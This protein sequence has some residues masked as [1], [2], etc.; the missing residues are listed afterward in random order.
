[1]EINIILWLFLM[2]ISLTL[3]IAGILK[4]YLMAFVGS[5]VAFTIVAVFDTIT[6][7]DGSVLALDW[8]TRLILGVMAV[9]LLM[10]SVMIP[11]R[12]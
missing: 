4:Q 8:I 5:V 3:I 9:S 7:I 12:D 1:M 2:G 11:S 10:I 6:M